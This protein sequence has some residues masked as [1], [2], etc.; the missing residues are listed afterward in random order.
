MVA[1]SPLFYD[2]SYQL[3]VPWARSQLQVCKVEQLIGVLE[4]KRTLVPI[5]FWLPN[6]ERGHAETSGWYW[7]AQY[8]SQSS[9][10]RAP[11]LKA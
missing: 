9:L 11:S 1:A 5:Q 2:N 8:P 7:D 6:W 4:S 3:Y 10:I